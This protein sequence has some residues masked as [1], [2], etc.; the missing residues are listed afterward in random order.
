[1][2]GQNDV[3]IVRQLREKW[4]E[5]PATRQERQFNSDLLRLSD[6]EL[7]D[8]WEDCR[9]QTSKPEVRGWFQEAYKE[10]LRGSRLADIG[11]GVGVDGIWFAQHGAYVTFVDIVADNLLLLE[12]LCG[13]KGISADYYFIDNFFEYRFASPFDCLLCVGSLINAP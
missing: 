9:V 13:L 5:I 1:M 8:Y 10:R 4:R 12:R 3:A 2:I 7:L 6:A 11:P